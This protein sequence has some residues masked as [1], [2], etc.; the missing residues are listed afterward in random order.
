MKRFVHVV[1]FIIMFHILQNQ[2][3]NSIESNSHELRNVTIEN[4][5]TQAIKV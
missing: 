4:F 2:E 5:I 3:V 1:L